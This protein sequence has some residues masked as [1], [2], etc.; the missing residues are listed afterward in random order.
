MVA[1]TAATGSRSLHRRLI[2]LISL[3]SLV[4]TYFYLSWSSVSTGIWQRFLD[5]MVK[6]R[7]AEK[8]F[9]I[10]EL[11]FFSSCFFN[12]IAL[13]IKYP[14]PLDCTVLAFFCGHFLHSQSFTT[15][16]TLLSLS[17]IVLP[18]ISACIT[19]SLYRILIQGIMFS[20][21]DETNNNATNK[22]KFKNTLAWCGLIYPL[23]L[24]LCVTGFALKYVLNLS[25]VLRNN[26][27][28]LS[29]FSIA[30]GVFYALFKVFLRAW[31]KR[32]VFLLYPQEYAV[33][34]ERSEKVEQG[35]RE[36][37]GLGPIQDYYLPKSYA[38][39]A[40][41]ANASASYSG[42]L[43]ASISTKQDANSIVIHSANTS[44]AV[45]AG[46]LA[47]AS[48][49]SEELF[50]PVTNF[51]SVATFS[52]FFAF[53]SSIL[54]SIS[55]K[56]LARYRINTNFIFWSFFLGAIVPG[57]IFMAKRL[58]IH[59]GREIIP[60]L[61][62]SQ[63]FAIQFAVLLTSVLALTLNSVVLAPSWYLLFSLAAVCSSSN[64][65][66][67]IDNSTEVAIETSSSAN[68]EANDLFF[69][70]SRSRKR[71]ILMAA[72]WACSI[73][74]SLCFGFTLAPY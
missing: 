33:Y 38:S 61:K 42:V 18:V 74:F 9:V 5:E 36:A 49:R 15:F 10:Y 39:S 21:T 22:D 68:P 60:N 71:I 8:M 46:K 62:Y 48:K 51:L 37:R 13:A 67:I 52:L 73:I 11:A 70:R 65:K 2:V 56:T 57:S 12:I 47:I 69:D 23:S 45:I 26:L 44:M 28:A 59:V 55:L 63:A 1:F 54:L 30:T 43:S 20:E 34:M 53:E 35:D 29:V 72:F 32:R 14:I 7:K 16:L 31:L 24:A 40:A 4:F 41:A 64:G 50:R 58:C 27:L 17:F 66:F 3:T 19:W 25:T 6:S